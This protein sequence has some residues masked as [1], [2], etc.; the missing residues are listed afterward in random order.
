MAALSALATRKTFK[1]PLFDYV[2]QMKNDQLPTYQDILKSLLY[3]KKQ[4]TIS[5]AG[6]HPSITQICSDLA[7]DIVRIYMSASIPT[8]SI[9]RIVASIKHY[10][11]KYQNLIKP[12]KSSCNKRSYQDKVKIFMEQSKQLFDVASC[13][14]VD[15]SSCKCIRDKKVSK[16]E[17]PFLIDQKNERKLFIGSI[18]KVETNIIMRREARKRKKDLATPPKPST[19]KVILPRNESFTSCASLTSDEEF[20]PPKTSR[21]R[22]C[23]QKDTT[24]CSQKSNEGK[25]EIKAKSLPLFAE[26][27]DRFGVSDRGAAFLSTS[28]LDDIGIVKTSSSDNII[29]RYV[30]IILGT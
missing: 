6:K 29:D 12:Y 24:K 17:Q 19:S 28:L 10:H 5:N 22:I 14:C 20:E 15:F 21:K 18:D 23:T 9:Q 27:C 4:L 11:S 1:Y 8:V 2:C 16:A 30:N 13:K 26:A 7:N 3:K 25:S